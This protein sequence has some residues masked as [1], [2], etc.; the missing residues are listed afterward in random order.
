[1]DD[2]SATL[3]VRLGLMCVRRGVGSPQALTTRLALAPDRVARWLGGDAVP[4]VPCLVL[5]ARALGTSVSHLI[6]PGHERSDM[7]ATWTYA[8]EPQL[9]RFRGRLRGAVRLAGVSSAGELASRAGVTKSCVLSWMRGTRLPSATSLVR[10]SRTLGVSC[11][12][13]LG[14]DMEGG[15][16]WR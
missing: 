9:L 14:F 11:D 15:R 2:L 8:Q 16:P 12:W 5:V 6:D 10:L 1:M 13:L 3:A 7:D 4:S